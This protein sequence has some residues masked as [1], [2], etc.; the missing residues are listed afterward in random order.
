MLLEQK[1]TQQLLKK[2]RISLPRTVLFNGRLPE[3]FNFPA[4]LKVDSSHV[5]HKTELGMVFTNLRN[6]KEVREKAT[7][8]RIVLKKKGI[9]EYSFV[10]QEMVKGTELIIGMKKDST[11]GPVIV[12]GLGGIFVEVLKDVSMRIAPL[13]KSDCEEMIEE[14]KS[15]KLLEGYRNLPKVNKA[16]LIS[17]LQK[18]SAMAAKEK[19]ISEMDFNPVI[20]DEKQAVVVDARILRDENA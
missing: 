3:K 4:V 18:V 6:M 14:L 13:K 15:K 8:A 2:Y 17:L 16:E 1:K 5:I 20:A 11:F 10:L 12:F 9:E 19:W 7:E